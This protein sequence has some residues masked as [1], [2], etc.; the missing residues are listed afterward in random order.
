MGERFIVGWPV[1]GPVGRGWAARI[2]RPSSESVNRCLSL[3]VT[4]CRRASGESLHDNK[5]SLPSPL[6]KEIGAHHADMGRICPSY[7]S[8]PSPPALKDPMHGQWK[9]TTTPM[10]GM[11]TSAVAAQLEHA[12]FLW[13]HKASKLLPRQKASPSTLHL[14]LG[15]RLEEII[16]IPSPVLAAFAPLGP[17]L[18]SAPPIPL[19]YPR[20]GAGGDRRGDVVH[21]G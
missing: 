5:R 1:P 19:T 10:E 15:V 13:E 18:K 3:S 14:P 16:A 4:I 6:S 2:R 17:R 9:Q 21:I 11:E 12:K 20:K 8:A 7:G